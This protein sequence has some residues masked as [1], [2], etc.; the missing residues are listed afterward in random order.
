MLW[1]SLCRYEQRGSSYT[2]LWNS[3]FCSVHPA[4][5]ETKRQMSSSHLIHY[6]VPSSYFSFLTTNP[7]LAPLSLP[8]YAYSPLS[9]SSYFCFVLFSRNIIFLY[10]ITKSIYLSKKKKLQFFLL[11]PFPLLLLSFLLCVLFSSHFA[12][13]T[14]A[15]IFHSFAFLSVRHWTSNKRHEQC[16]C[17]ILI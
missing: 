17:D 13:L 5:D 14:K 15:F 1:H 8:P 3:S 4:K 10:L 9:P 7:I 6:L 11:F 16:Q 2:F 12:I